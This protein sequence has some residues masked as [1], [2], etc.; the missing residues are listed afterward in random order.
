VEEFGEE[1]TGALSKVYRLSR[2][3]VPSSSQLLSHSPQEAI[4]LM[5]LVFRASTNCPSVGLFLEP[6]YK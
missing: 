2:K 1:A 3:V 4:P 5:M 6:Q